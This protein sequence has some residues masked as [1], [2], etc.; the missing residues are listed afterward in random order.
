MSTDAFNLG[1]MVSD[2]N[3]SQVINKMTDVRIAVAKSEL[4]SFTPILA[5]TAV[6]AAKRA[7]SKA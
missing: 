3:D 5:N 6:S 1:R 4:I 2:K 7:E